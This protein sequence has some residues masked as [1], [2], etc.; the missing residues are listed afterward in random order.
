M[1]NNLIIFPAID[2]MGGKVVRLKQGQFDKST[3]YSDDPVVMAKK[4]KMAGAQWVHVVDLDGAKTG[5][6]KNIEVIK[7]IAQ[8]VKVPVQ[9]GGGIRSIEKAKELLAEE[10]IKRIVVGTKSIGDEG[11]LNEL[12]LKWQDRVAV[13]IDCAE[14][15]VTQRGWVEKTDVKG[16]DLAVQLQQRGIKCIIY[17]DIKRDGM[18]QGPN[19]QRIEE[20]LNTVKIDVIASGGVSNET[21]IQR[22]C[23][24]KEK[25]A[26]LVG[27]ITGKAIYEKT[28]GFQ[29][30]VYIAGN[31]KK[32]KGIS[33]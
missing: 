11:L 30:A 19:L 28:L 2:I 33:S 27:V 29:S 15:L 20:I 14:G 31:Y 32:F 4:W 22:L 17:T 13:S 23:A 9:V 3:D 10:G 12:I 8:E 21:D 1:S 26:H 6:M 25:Y 16:T 7:R 18:M 24:L 5:E